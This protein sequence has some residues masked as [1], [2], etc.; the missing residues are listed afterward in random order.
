MPEPEPVT[1]KCGAVLGY[2]IRV[3]GVQLFR[4]GPLVVEELHGRCVQC[5]AGVHTSLPSSAYRRL[6]ARYGADGG[7]QVEIAAPQ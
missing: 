6:M 5:G 7:L 3:D 1:C 4:V 2:A